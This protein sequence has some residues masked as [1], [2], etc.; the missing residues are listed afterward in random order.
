[1]GYEACGDQ[2]HF[3]F[4]LKL[5]MNPINAVH[6]CISN[7]YHHNDDHE[8]DE[9]DDHYDRDGGGGD[10]DDLHSNHQSIV[11]RSLV[12]WQ[13]GNCCHSRKCFCRGSNTSISH[14]SAGF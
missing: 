3:P 6:S 13:C 4:E 5:S 12:Y 9:D 8:D 2:I 1:M 7:S 14:Q 10:D 11:N